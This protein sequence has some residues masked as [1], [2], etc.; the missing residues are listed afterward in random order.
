M[1]RYP[2][3]HQR[4][5]ILAI[6]DACTAAGISQNQVAAYLRVSSPTL[7]RWREQARRAAQKNRKA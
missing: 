2:H 1:R 6:V 3:P 7:S 4:A 5:E